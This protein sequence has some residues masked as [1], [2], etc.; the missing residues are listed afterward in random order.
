MDLVSAAQTGSLFMS[1]VPFVS[2]VPFLDSFP[3]SS[4]GVS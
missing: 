2:F 3:F 1:F 4:S